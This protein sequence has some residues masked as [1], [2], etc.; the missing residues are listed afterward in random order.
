MRW[1]LLIAAA[2]LHAADSPA[3]FFEAKVRPVF[4]K[5]CFA[6]HT[7]S[8]LGGLS[9]TTRDALLKGGNS[10][11][12]VMAG[13][14]EASLLV[15]AITHQHERIK[16]PPTGTKLADPEIAAIKTWIRDGAVWPET[17]APKV[18]SNWWAFQPI[19]N[20]QPPLAKQKPIDAF[21]LA[22]QQA[23]G[24]KP[25]PPADRRTLIRRATL[26]LTGLPATAAEIAAFVADKTPD[27]FAQVIDRLLASPHYGE[28]WG[29]QWL[30][31][32][33]YSDDKLNSTM[34]EPRPN[35]FRYRDWVID[36]FNRDLPFNEFAKAQIAGDLLGQP[37]ATGLYAL[38][39]EFQDDRVDV[40]TRGFLALTVACAQCHDHK[41]DPI[42][43]K[44]Y[45]SLLGIFNSSK[46]HE[47]PLADESV[48]DDWQARKKRL[49]TAQQDL[50]D[51]YAKQAEQLSEIF[52]AKGDLYL[53][54]A[55]G[56]DAGQLDKETVGKFKKYLA[57]KDRL[58]KI[59]A[60]P[61]VF[62][63][64]L[65][66]V[67]KEKKDVD[68][69]NNIRLGGSKVR[70]DLSQADLLSLAPEKFYLWRDFYRAGGVFHYGAGNIDRFLDGQ[71]KQHLELLK[72]NVEHLKKELPEQY[73]FLHALS[74]GDKPR[75][76]RVHI[77]GNRAN[78]GDVAPRGWLTVLSKA[79]PERFQNGS[80]RL[81]LAESIAS[82]DNPLTPRVIVNRI[83]QGHFGEGLVRSTSNF[84]RL[85]EMP[86]HP[87]LLDWLA[88]S[89][90]NNG[91]SMKKLHREIMLSNAYQMATANTEGDNRLLTHFPARRLDA[92]SL[93]DSIL[94]VTGRLDR[95]L[96]GKPF[97]LDDTAQTR[98]TV[99]GFVSRRRTDTMLNL[100][101]FPNPNATSERRVATDVP[102][103]RLFL[104][105]SPLMIES[106]EALDKS[107]GAGT[108][109]E[110]IRK[111]YRAVLGRAPAKQE[112][113]LGLEWAGQNKWAQYW[114]V[115]LST[116]EFLTIQ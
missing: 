30:D 18:V 20:P 4:A 89:F 26:D 94:A 44:D 36:A 110:R 87:E 116:D 98:R 50:T 29:R 103:Q 35:A 38:S 83:W 15:R 71:W 6:C 63:E 22:A 108:P 31:V 97:R 112:I 70:S 80:G 47:L 5:H 49:D 34:D 16:M 81:Q 3:E 105:N 109:E 91:W 39:P 51:F 24:L 57:R 104:L 111:G 99:Y 8:K 53:K 25:A 65:I 56:G 60:D 13:E 102:L 113:A 2:S 72:A 77:R 10:G 79:A 69:K 48:V 12:A 85:G 11:P 7:Q 74:E 76:E 92:E 95:A 43:T 73:P 93:R 96:G 82:N 21:L 19:G 75:D 52:A 41:F 90:M 68:A 17:L 64:A 78:Q 100:F 55:E 86:S 107:I 59:A 45:Y 33:R 27:A 37:A 84:G 40:T 106:A 114:Q 32:A 62:R 23:K 101:D 14:P 58:A 1:H 66:D 9:M 115:L 46:T 88:R 28:R 61:V 42:P 67:Q 54:A